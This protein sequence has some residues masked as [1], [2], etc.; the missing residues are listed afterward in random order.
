MSLDGITASTQLACEWSTVPLTT[1]P[2]VGRAPA[3]LAGVVRHD[4]EPVNPGEIRVTILGS[5]D[6]SSGRGRHRPR[7]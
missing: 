4:A 3:G 1:T 5:G 6:P 2:I 7:C